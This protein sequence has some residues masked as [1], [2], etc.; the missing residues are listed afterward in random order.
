MVNKTFIIGL[1]QAILVLSIFFYMLSESSI[2]FL[3]FLCHK[4]NKLQVNKECLFFALSVELGCFH[5]HF[6]QLVK[7]P[8]FLF[9]IFLSVVQFVFVVSYNITLFL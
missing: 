8:L 5:G 9:F 4:T 3:H 7:E 1:W 6:A 2:F